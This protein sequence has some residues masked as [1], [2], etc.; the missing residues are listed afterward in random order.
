MKGY[1]E[2]AYKGYTD[3]WRYLLGFFFVFIVWQMG[4]VIQVGFVVNE[5]VQ[6]GQSFED[7]M[8]QSS[9]FNISTEDSM[10]P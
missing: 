10:N 7:A 1:I 6:Q 4:A 8:L 3:W 2:Q 5:L 9:T